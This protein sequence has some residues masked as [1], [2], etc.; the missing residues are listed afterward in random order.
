MHT[1]V[2]RFELVS[3]LQKDEMVWC[4][5]FLISILSVPFAV[6]GDRHRKR[7]LRSRGTVIY[8]DMVSIVKKRPS[9][10]SPMEQIR[11]ES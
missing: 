11:H 1:F 10:L 2:S 8:A 9:K 5:L 6:R 4:V 7:D 3:F